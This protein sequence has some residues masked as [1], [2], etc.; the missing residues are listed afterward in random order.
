MPAPSIQDSHLRGDPPTKKLVKEIDIDVA[1][2]S[3]E[4]IATAWGIGSGHRR[5]AQLIA[6]GLEARAVTSSWPS[7]NPLRSDERSWS[8]RPEPRHY[9]RSPRIVYRKLSL[10]TER[11]GIERVHLITH[12]RCYAS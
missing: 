9:R 12:S 7:Q 2:M 3:G 8:Y 5:S 1:E 10:G 4:L 6:I 11:L